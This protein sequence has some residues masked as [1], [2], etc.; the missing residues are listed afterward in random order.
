MKSRV[1]CILSRQRG[2]GRRNDEI[3]N[4][5]YE[6]LIWESQ[7]CRG[8]SI[9]RGNLKYLKRSSIDMYI[10][11]YRLYLALKNIEVSVGC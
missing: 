6:K 11:I 7:F 10:Y 2:C 9:R 5:V 4:I 8:P 1:K 3:R